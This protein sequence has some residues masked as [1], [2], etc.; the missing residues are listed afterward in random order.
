[1]DVKSTFLNGVLNEEV[2]VHQPPG[3][4]VKTQEH[5]VYK[6]KKSLYDFKQASRA[7]YSR[8]DHYILKDGFSRRENE[9]TLYI[10]VNQ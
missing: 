2:Y 3:F 9:P 1:M 4:D 5:R 7:W 10:K 6:L 8:I